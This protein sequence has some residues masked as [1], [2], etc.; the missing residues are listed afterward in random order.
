MSEFLSSDRLADMTMYDQDGE[1]VG[2]VGQVYTGGPS[3]QAEWITVITGLL[4]TKETLVPLR[5]AEAVADQLHVPFTKEHI[6]DA[7]HADADGHLST[8][9]ERTLYAH[10]GMAGAGGEEALAGT[11]S[12]G[13]ADSRGEP[14][15]PGAELVRAEERLRVGTAEEVVGT[16]RLRKVVV[17]EHVTTTIP[18]RHEEVRVVREPVRPGDMVHGRIAEEDAE[19]TLHAERPV[20]SKEQVAVER[21]RL[22]TDQVTEEREVSDTVRKERIEFED[23]PARPAS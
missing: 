3:G 1:K 12:G 20:V 7:P 8:A 6:K 14:G 13:G 18:V 9:E 5:G 15:H 23:G 10:Y 2:R 21:V 17:T 19:V 22:E 11:P 4:G 16:V